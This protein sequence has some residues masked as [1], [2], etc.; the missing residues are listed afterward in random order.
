MT[1]KAVSLSSVGSQ[2]RSLNRL[3]AGCKDDR[4]AYRDVAF[5]TRRQ[6]D[7]LLAMSRRRSV[8][9]EELSSIV[10]R[11]GGSPRRSGSVFAGL[12]RTMFEMRATVSGAHHL[13][14]ELA[15]C[16]RVGGDV[17]HTYDSAMKGT[18]WAK[19]TKDS[20]QAQ[21]DELRGDHDTVREWRGAL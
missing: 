20:V 1:T 5:A 8:F 11:L 12:R 18:T 4:K 3:I 7:A 9:I 16:A 10:R 2:R 21:L 19:D 15:E 6:K 14:D 13:G 17:V